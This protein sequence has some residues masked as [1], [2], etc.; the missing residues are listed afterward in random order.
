MQMQNKSAFLPMLLQ[1]VLYDLSATQ[2]KSLEK[3][4]GN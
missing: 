3:V 2:A 4:D 1:M